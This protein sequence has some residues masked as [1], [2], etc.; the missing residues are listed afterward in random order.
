MTYV[1]IVPQ[2]PTPPSPRARELADRL[3]KVVLEYEETHPSVTKDEVRQ[4]TQLA[5]QAARAT[6]PMAAPT[7]ALGLGLLMFAGLAAFYFVGD[8][9]LG[10]GGMPWM[11]VAAIGVLAIV[12]ALVT[13]LRRA[14]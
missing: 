4:A 12:G 2:P 11:V 7:L 14:P 5:L 1:P 8:I 6:T 10:S 3:L 9:D 13:V